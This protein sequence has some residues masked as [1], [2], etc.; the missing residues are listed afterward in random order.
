MVNRHS[1]FMGTA[2]L[3]SGLSGLHQIIMDYHSL[4][5]GVDDK[6]AGITDPFGAEA[7]PIP[8]NA[9]SSVIPAVAQSR[10]LSFEVA[11]VKVAQGDFLQ[12]RPSRKGG[13]GHLD[14]RSL[15]PDRLRIRTTAISHVGSDSRKH[16]IYAVEAT[17][18]P[19]ASEDDVRLMFQT[20]LK[21]R[22]ELMFHTE[23]KNIFPDLSFPWLR[24]V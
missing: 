15:V 2:R 23:R 19:A 12:R 20:L 10:P 17:F 8:P 22:F 1:S 3:F 7:S 14:D 16:H 9:M 6:R 13:R 24:E 11:S 4:K 18:D 21:S 5:G